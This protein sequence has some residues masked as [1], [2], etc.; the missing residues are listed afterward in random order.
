MIGTAWAA[1]GAAGKGSFFATPEFWVAVAFVLFIV[2]FGKKIW[3][4]VAGMLDERA[5]TI[6]RQLDEAQKLRQQAEALL[7]EY[8]QKQRD[9][10]AEAQGIVAQ[11]REEAARLKQRGADE[12]V[13]AIKLRERQAIDRIAQA[14]AKAL[15]D[16]R[17][18]AVDVA[19]AA[20]QQLL[21][22][23]VEGSPQAQSALID[24]GIAELP[25]R[26]N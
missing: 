3:T 26:L 21:R 5:A 10:V 1:D 16:V 20:T 6:A 18:M 8:Q 12:L 15:A 24:A 23:Q 4:A 11:A 13:A 19:L 14:E 25:K 7:A 2:L 9:A 17:N 22:Q